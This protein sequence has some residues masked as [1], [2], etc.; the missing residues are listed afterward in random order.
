MKTRSAKPHWVVLLAVVVALA[1]ALAAAGCGG[2]EEP[3]QE[4]GGQPAT[5]TEAPP[6][7][8]TEAPPPTT[9]AETEAEA[10]PEPAS[11]RVALDWF[12]NPDHVSL[13]YALEN[14]HW[15]DQGLDIELKTPS[16]PSAGL[17]LVA[18]GQFDLAIYYSADTY[19]AAEQGVPVVAVASLVP[20]PLNSLISLADSKVTGP[21]TIQ[22]AKIGVAGLP[23]DDAVLKTIRDS[24][25]LSEDD[26]QAVNV[27][28]NLEPALLSKKVD[29]V[30]GAY[31]NIEATSIE[32]KTEAA[33]NV[34]SMESLG[35]PTYDEL[36]VVANK[37]RIES[38]PAFADAVSRF[39]AG[40][41]LG[42]EGAQ[43]D[44]AGS[45]QLMKDNTDY[46]AEEIDGMVP[47]TLALLTP[48]DGRVTT[49]FDLDNWQAL[50]DWMVEKD[51]LKEPIDATT[52]ATNDYN[53][54]GC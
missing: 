47:D 20:V 36:L 40:M 22:G 44:E 26:V 54:N 4:A 35:V 16:D 15:A 46:S 45:I 1:A 11:L 14:G 42:V 50:G 19:F 29:A 28:F 8:E 32:I 27:G 48:P 24:Q 25:G 2:G 34:I 17:K 9:E 18:S 23:F 53:P 31:F 38:D 39:I 5:E 51:L 7:T 12:P 41:K 10:A 49:C 52:V 21:E 6:A 13:Y 43:A 33:P 37:E 30:I 3:A